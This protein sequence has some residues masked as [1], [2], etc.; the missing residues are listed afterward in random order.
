M[1]G[2]RARVWQLPLRVRLTL[3]GTLLLT[4]A[5]A[6]VFGLV[7]V[8]FEA[9]LNSAIDGDL[10][11]RAQTLAVVVRREGPG[12]I[13]RVDAQELLRSLGAF[14]QVVDQHGRALSSTSAVTRMH[15]L[16]PAQ[17]ATAARKGLRTDHG[18]IPHVAKRVRLVAAPLSGTR[19]GDR[20][21]PLA[22]RPRGRERKLRA[23]AADRRTA[24]AAALSGRLLSRHRG[25][26][27][28]R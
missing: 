20:R 25:R 6:V 15:L 18:S 10:R 7:F 24:R 17:A 5:L 1:T 23:C 2:L 9:G 22:Q 8:R 19:G 13:Q 14:A 27:A 3:A 16:T 26:A 28:A 21:R 11:A 4:V 12:A